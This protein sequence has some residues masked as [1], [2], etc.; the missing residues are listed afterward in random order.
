[1]P[2][3]GPCRLR[4]EMGDGAAAG[5]PRPLRSPGME[6]SWVRAKPPPDASAAK[7]TPGTWKAQGTAAPGARRRCGSNEKADGVGRDSA[8]LCTHVG[9]SSPTGLAKKS[10]PSPSWS[11]IRTSSS[12]PSK[13]VA[14]AGGRFRSRRERCGTSH[15]PNRPVYKRWGSHPRPGREKARNSAGAA[16]HATR[17]RGGG[18]FLG[19]PMRPHAEEGRGTPGPFSAKTAPNPGGERSDAQRPRHMSEALRPPPLR[20]GWAGKEPGTQISARRDDATLCPAPAGAGYYLFY[21]VGGPKEEFPMLF[22]IP[23][24][25]AGRS[26]RLPGRRYAAQDLHAG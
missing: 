18:G 2:G 14:E 9:S 4:G 23:L 22:A 25:A 1:V 24:F 26:G 7:S 21:P 13:A 15:R 20:E 3:A 10:G 19:G 17:P 11:A 5:P 6:G 16:H 12:A 8:T